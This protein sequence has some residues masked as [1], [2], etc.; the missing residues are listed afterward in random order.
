MD[1][2]HITGIIALGLSLLAN[3]PY[4][5]ET[6]QGKVKPERVSWFIWTLLGIVYF[7][8]AV[9]EQGAILFTAGELIGPLVAFL[10]ALKYGV[11]GKSKLDIT[12]LVLALL[13]IGWLVVTDN[14]LVGVL[15]ALTADAI[16][17]V[18]TIRKLHLDPSSESRWAWGIFAI[19]GIFALLS[20]RNISVETLLFPVYVLATSLY[21]TIRV[22]VSTRR[23]RQ[24]TLSS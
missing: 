8:T 23:D 19:S 4:V 7:W 10:L 2:H 16:A 20:I 21:I 6:I 12:M 3:I 24:R 18:L 5:I 11:G 17:M 15:L 13:A 22:H 9:I 14:A 1:F